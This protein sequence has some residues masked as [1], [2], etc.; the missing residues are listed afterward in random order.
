MGPLEN[1]C[2]IRGFV[3]QRIEELA[4]LSTYPFTRFH[5]THLHPQFRT[6]QFPDIGGLYGA[7]ALNPDPNSW[8]FS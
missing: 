3:L 5:S 2:I 8:S 6:L 4:A 1:L 7:L